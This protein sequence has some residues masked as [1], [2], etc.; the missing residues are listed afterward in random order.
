MIDWLRGNVIG[1]GEMDWPMKTAV[2][3][4]GVTPITLHFVQVNTNL[5]VTESVPTYAPYI[6]IL[7]L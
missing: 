3:R 5:P 1:R 7:L 6:S 2:I 4:L